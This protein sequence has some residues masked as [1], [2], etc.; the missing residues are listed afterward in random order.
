MRFFIP[1][2]ARA[3]SHALLLKLRAPEGTQ[4]RKLALVELK[5]KDRVTKKNVT[6][7]LA[8]RADYA[9]SDAASAAT[10]DPN[11]SRTIQGFLAGEAL[12]TAAARVGS[13]DMPAAAALL[14]EREAILRTAATQLAEPGFL[15]DADR[16][17]RLRAHASGTSTVTEP[18]ALAMPS[19]PPPTPTCTDRIHPPQSPR[20][21][22]PEQSPPERCPPRAPR[23]SAAPRAAPPASVVL[24]HSVHLRAPRGALTP[25]RRS[26]KSAGLNPDAAANRREVG[27]HPC[28]ERDAG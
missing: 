5:Y 4:P 9:E 14:G 3:D 19:K 10:R 25:R 27:G 11:V 12:M 15:R 21:K 7:E 24:V 23:G 8:V 16:L 18:L 20:A 1:A 13:G 17:A 26:W 2:F 6:V 28:G 22:S